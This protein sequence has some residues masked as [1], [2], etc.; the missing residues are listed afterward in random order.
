MSLRN[1]RLSN[2]ELL[3]L[4]KS[5]VTR[6]KTTLTAV[7]SESSCA[8]G[9]KVMY[10]LLRSRFDGGG[11]VGIDVV[12]LVAVTAISNACAIYVVEVFIR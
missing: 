2:V 8:Y 10:T 1:K 3:F 5:M 11:G 6:F 12:A 7:I 4:R 9:S